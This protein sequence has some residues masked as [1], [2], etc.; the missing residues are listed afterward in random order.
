MQIFIQ[1]HAV[2]GLLRVFKVKPS[3]DLVLIKP[4]TVDTVGTD[5]PPSLHLSLMFNSLAA[6]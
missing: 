5:E 1:I 6:A 3:S 4:A 2:L